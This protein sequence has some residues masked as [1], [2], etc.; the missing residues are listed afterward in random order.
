MALD[1]KQTS[2][3]WYGRFTGANGR[4]LLVNLNVKIAG[5]RP[6]HINDAGPDVD[7]RFI[8][9]RGK[10]LQEHDR[11]QQD[12]QAKNNLIETQEKLVELKTGERMES[13]KLA[14]LEQAW[15]DIE[16]TKTPS[17]SHKNTCLLVVRSFVNY[18]KDHAPAARELIDVTKA[19]A[20]GFLAAAKKEGYAG[21]SLNL[22]RDV[23]RT[24]YKHHLPE[25]EVYR[26]YLLNVPAQDEE[27]IHRVP[28]TPFE[29][30]AIMDTVRGD[31]F[32]RPLVVTGMCTSMRQGDVCRLQWKSVDMEN[33]FVSVRTSKTGESVDVPIFPLLFDELRKRPHGKPA[34]YL[35]PDAAAMYK[36]NRYGIGYRVKKLLLAALYKD[37]SAEP[38]LARLS[39]EETRRNVV[40]HCATLGNQE[41]AARMVAVFDAYAGGSS[42]KKMAAV[43]V[44]AA[45][46]SAYLNEIE[47]QTKCQIFRGHRE[48][49]SISTLLRADGANLKVDRPTGKRRASVRDFHSLRVTW[50]TLA[51]TAGVPLELVRRVTGHKTIEIV[52]KHYFQPGREDFRRALYAAMPMLMTDGTAKTAEQRVRD[53]LEKATAKTWKRDIAKALAL[54]GGNN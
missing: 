43:N 7:Q 37:D 53:F 29:L 20:K 48:G 6:P 1:W 51:L 24:L 22:R 38:K 44:S 39:P 36:A 15:I 19:D 26:R 34:D 30:K 31:D 54:L 32:L 35:F 41:R 9:S 42:V 46:A 14:E 2:Q 25:S 10:A 50:I 3:W 4:R 33:R 18:L 11:I 28:F 23:L 21:R 40:E 52:L 5:V 49:K 45:S 16:R 13:V 17:D 8:E 12:I 27:T 47:E